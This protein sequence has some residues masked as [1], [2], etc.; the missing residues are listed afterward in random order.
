MQ[1]REKDSEETCLLQ[2]YEAISYIF[3]MECLLNSTHTQPLLHSISCIL[4]YTC[5][6]LYQYAVPICI[7]TRSQEKEGERGCLFISRR[8]LSKYTEHTLHI[9]VCNSLFL[10][11][12]LLQT[13]TSGRTEG[14]FP[15]FI[16]HSYLYYRRISSYVYPQSVKG[17]L[18]NGMEWGSQTSQTSL[19]NLPRVGTLGK[20]LDNYWGIL[21]LHT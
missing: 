18:C 11:L 7:S 15:L 14:G 17:P 19:Q 20:D 10:L 4:T 1:R 8:Y 6:L 21:K 2:A 12:F 13:V 9:N 16:V 5:E 3:G